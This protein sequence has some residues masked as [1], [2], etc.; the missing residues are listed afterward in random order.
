MEHVSLHPR[1]G[2]AIQGIRCVFRRS[3]SDW[4]AH[5]HGLLAGYCTELS[6]QHIH[7]DLLQIRGL[8]D[9]IMPSGIFVLI[10]L[11]VIAIV[12][13]QVGLVHILIASVVSIMTIGLE[14]VVQLIMRVVITIGAENTTYIKN[15]GGNLLD[16]TRCN[17]L[18][19]LNCQEFI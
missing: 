17:A 6:V 9:H 8:S 19:H 15:I 11:L 16:V 18:H 4:C 1:L 13:V 10:V 3:L 14:F 7:G 5:V 2:I 12:V